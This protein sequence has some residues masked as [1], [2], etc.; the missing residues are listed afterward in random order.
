MQILNTKFHIPAPDQDTMVQR[1][2]LLATILAQWIEAGKRGFETTWISLEKR[3]N[4]WTSF[5]TYV[6]R[7]FQK[8]EPHVCDQAKGLLEAG[9]KNTDS[10]PPY[11]L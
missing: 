9:S 10:T 2:A 4:T 1:K 6:I 5:W 7:A 8:I 3:D 11:S